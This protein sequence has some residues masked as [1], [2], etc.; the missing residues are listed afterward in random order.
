MENPETAQPVLTGDGLV[1]RPW[2]TDDVEAVF[3][4]CQDADI[5][6]WTRVPVPYERVHAEQFVNEVA[7]AAWRSESGALFAVTERLGAPV[8][9]SI[10]VVE[11][12]GAVAEVG[13]WA[14]PAG[15][16]RGLMS[17]GARLLSQWCVDAG[18]ATLV[19]LLIHPSN[20]SSI[21]VAERAG[22][23]LAPEGS[24]AVDARGET[25]HLAVYQFSDR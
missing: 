17:A 12:R 24:R 16:H 18:R 4:A 14:A 20:V 19:E 7:P 13:Y 5:Q 10:G 1:L 3:A 6:R 23:Q 2:T 11:F 15:R 21:R 8:A 22:F 25:V 9:G